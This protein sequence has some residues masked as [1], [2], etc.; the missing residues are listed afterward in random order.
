MLTASINHLQSIIVP[1][2]IF[3]L[4]DVDKS[5]PCRNILHQLGVRM[6]HKLQFRGNVLKTNMNW[7]A[8]L[9]IKG[10]MS[11]PLCQQ[12]DESCF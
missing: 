12:F 8:S 6:I 3:G 7:R 4:L 10:I 5:L 1:H 2:A 11:H 9:T